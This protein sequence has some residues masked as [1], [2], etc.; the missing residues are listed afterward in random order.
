[1]GAQPTLP[2]TVFA[3][4]LKFLHELGLKPEAAASHLTQ[5]AGKL[6]TTLQGSDWPGIARLKFS[7]NQN[8]E[9]ARWLHGFLLF[10]LGKLPRGRA[11]AIT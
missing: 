1:M 8:E 4:E 7:A 2:Q 3:F 6:V 9:V 11:A 10:H 5:G